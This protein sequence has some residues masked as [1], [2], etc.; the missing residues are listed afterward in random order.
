MLSQEEA[1]KTSK[2]ELIKKLSLSSP[3]HFLCSEHEGMKVELYCEKCNVVVC[4]TCTVTSHK[5]HPVHEA[6]EE[7]KKRRH[8]IVENVRDFRMKKERIKK[9]IKN[10]EEIGNKIKIFKSDVNKVIKQ[11]CSNLQQ[12]IQERER[13]LL[14][15]SNEIA[16]AKNARISLRLEGFQRLLESM[17]QCHA[18]ASAATTEYSDVQLLS[19]AKTLQDR[20][21]CLQQQ[22]TDTA[23]HLSETPDIF[24]NFA[25]DELSSLLSS[26]G[27]ISEKVEV[28]NSVLVV[29]P[30][31]QVGIGAKMR[32][33]VILKCM[34][35]NTLSSGRESIIRAVLS[36]NK[37]KLAEC[38]VVN[39]GD[40]TYIIILTFKH[41]GLNELCITLNSQQVQG[42]PFTFNVIPQRDYTK[43]TATINTVVDVP[44]PRY[45][46]IADSGDLFV[47]SSNKHCIYHLDS[48]GKKKNIIGS[49]G[50]GELQFKSPCGI[51]VNGDVVYVAEWEGKRIHK[52]STRGEFL[53][54]IEPEAGSFHRPHD[55]KISSDRKIFVVDKE[56]DCIKVLNPNFSVSHCIDGRVFGDGNFNV[57]IGIDFDLL[58]N[59]HISCNSSHFVAVFSL[60]GQFVRRYKQQIDLPVG[61]TI[62]P[63]GFS[64]VRDYAY[65]SLSI[66]DPCGKF[67]N[68]IG[69]F[70]N[71][72]GTAVA[73]NGSLW[74]ADNGNNRLV[75]I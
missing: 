37:A 11:V 28:D 8:K 61:V 29:I 44:D 34:S 31:K 50:N 6:S 67:V 33:T 65:H 21:I 16:E 32:V 59:V 42:S 5:S 13:T 25:G 22:F 40:G 73:A 62:D 3:L 69:G 74:V 17:C 19:I 12:L 57:P 18:L 48:K 71:S 9:E 43:V 55:V 58:G 14:A 10:G 68:S 66:F 51:T 60:I 49:K 63:S 4:G 46:A 35:R 72:Y 52:L 24:F 39:N 54:I 36:T 45:I 23:L 53:G 38:P 26:F 7:V 1:Q 75:K 56:K 64:I 41:L 70:N 15:E 2:E 30:R 27:C 20:A 47:T